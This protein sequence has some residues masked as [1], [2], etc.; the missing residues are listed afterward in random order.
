MN[1]LFSSY[2][3]VINARPIGRKQIHFPQSKKRRIRKKWA[4]QPKNFK[5]VFQEQLLVDSVNRRIIGTS[6]MIEQ[7]RQ[8]LADESANPTI[9]QNETNS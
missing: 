5:N 3:I 7:M 8:S 9:N 1:A 6:R 4:K 2:N